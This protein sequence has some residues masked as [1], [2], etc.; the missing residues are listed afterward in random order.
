MIEFVK[1]YRAQLAAIFISIMYTVGL[2]H[3]LYFGRTEIM[4]L[5]PLQLMLSLIVVLIFIIDKN[6]LSNTLALISIYILGLSIEIIGV[7]TAF[8]FGEYSYGNILG[9]KIAGTPFLIGVNWV[10]VIVGATALAER[11]LPNKPKYLRIVTAATLALLLDL[12]IEPV[13]VQLQMWSWTEGT[14]P[15]SNYLAWWILA[16]I[17][18]SIY[19]KWGNNSR[20]WVVIIVFLWLFLFFGSLN[21]YFS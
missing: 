18:T 3:L 6:Q 9:P 17:F 19:Q 1:I 10:L 15:F 16:T 7:Q 20:H 12:L 8:P 14:I 2:V 5:T 13:A 11:L 4:S 21:L